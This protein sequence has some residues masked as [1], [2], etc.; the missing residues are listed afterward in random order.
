MKAIINFCTIA[1]VCLCCLTSISLF[2]QVTIELNVIS[3]SS[4]TTCDDGV[5]GGAP[6]PLWQVNVEGEGALTYPANGPCFTAFPNVQYSN[7]V[8]CYLDVPATIEVCFTAF[9]NDGLVIPIIGTCDIAA[10]C[11]ETVC[12]DF[13]VPAIGTTEAFSLALPNNLSSGGAVNFEIAVSEDI[14]NNFICN[15]IDLGVVGAGT[16][17]GDSSIGA[18]SNNC[19][20]D[21]NDISTTDFGIFED[22]NTVWFSFTTG[23]DVGPQIFVDVTNDPENT[24]DLLDV[25]IALFETSDG[26]CTGTPTLVDSEAPINSLD[27]FMDFKC[28]QPN[29]TYYLLV[30][31][32]YFDPNETV[33]GIFG[34]QLTNVVAT[35]A[36]DTPCGADDLG[37]VPEGGSTSLN[38][39]YSNFCATGTGDINIP[40]FGT[41]TSVWFRFTPPSSGH[42][43]VEATAEPGG[44]DPLDIQM[45]VLRSFGSCTGVFIHLES[46]DNTTSLDQSLEV[47]C[48]YDDEE[49]WILVDGAV[50]NQYGTFTLSVTDAG[51]ITP[52]GVVDTTICAGDSYTVVGSTYTDTGTYFDTIPVFF[53]CDSV[54][55]T[56]LTVLDPIEIT[57]NQTLPAVNQGGI[58]GQAEVSAIGGDGNYS[59]AWCTGE[60]GTMANMLVGGEECCVTVT[61]DF[62]CE[63]IEC[64]TVEFVTEIIP[65]FE[66]DTLLCNGDTDGII[67]FSAAD[68]YPPY[69]YTWEKNDGTINGN[70]TIMA[71]GDQVM[72]PNLPA[73]DYSITITDLFFDTTFVASVIEPTLVEVVVDEVVPASCFEFC[74]GSISV[75][76]VGGAGNYTYAWSNGSTSAMNIDLCA[77][78]YTV[79]ITDENGCEAEMTITITEPDE[80][81]AT[82]TQTQAVSCFEGIDGQATVTTNGNPTIFAWET[83]DDTPDVVGLSA[84]TYM[85]TVTNED[86]CLDTTFVD[87]TQPDSPVSVQ[88]GVGN[89]ISCAG[90]ADGSLL[91]NVSGPGT[92]FSYNWTNGGTEQNTT[93]LSSEEYSVTVSNELG[94]EAIASVFLDEPLPIQADISTIDITCLDPENGGIILI[95]TVTGGNGGYEYSLDG[96]I[97]S[98]ASGFFNLFE[99]GYEIAIRDGKG[100]EEVFPVT[101]MG[102]PEL[103][104]DLGM[105]DEVTQGEIIDLVAITNGGTNLVYTWTPIDS[106]TV[107]ADSTLTAQPI[108]STVFQVVVED[109]VSFCTAIDQIAIAVNRDRKIYMANAFSPN[110]DGAN[111]KFM[112]QSGVGVVQV[113]SFR[114]F[115]R[116]GALVFEQTNFQPNDPD[117]GWDGQFNGRELN[118]GVYVFM[119]EIEFLDGLTEV[120]KGDVMLMR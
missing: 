72:L 44:L 6:D 20:D 62:G 108:E 65:T 48:L 113:K 47:S 55:Q 107:V 7:S 46:D 52:I 50:A 85:V 53:A 11:S 51:D 17:I 66:N 64:F 23:P 100:C 82:A 87:I 102:P 106:T 97:F 13:N 28:V 116:Y 109:T 54:I 96:V 30:D 86:G 45:A 61:D 69:E 29:T 42:V 83:G 117:F 14:S 95:D 99:G 89:P 32:G 110:N 60:T 111:D 36:S 38:G 67:T 9:E 78:D 94:C 80:F 71:A 5:F 81:I 88:I 76:G 34:L 77:G 26:T 43:L 24:G 35:E 10:E 91:A 3:G 18:Y 75:S 4:T 93:G 40:A 98:S 57:I 115:D 114:V 101:V 59:F 2:S 104:V 103:V 21:D 84:G 15:A 12:Q 33:T 68:G 25:Q 63:S 22:D 120:F 90:E 79:T 41:Q 39:F 16:I 27:A 73:G 105:D 70:G 118:T 112:V 31:G 37:V 49:Y 74:D 119:A 19:S 8:D 56:N 1:M 58:N 92:N